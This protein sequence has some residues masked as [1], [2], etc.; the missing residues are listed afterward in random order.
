MELE[1]F[2]KCLALNGTNPGKMVP[3][4][5]GPRKIGSPRK[6]ELENFE[7]CLALNG[8]NPG[9]M[10]SGKMAP[11]KNGPGKMPPPPPPGKND[12]WK[13]GPR[14]TQKRKIMGWVSSIVVCAWNVGMWSIYENPKLDNK[15]KTRKQRQN[16]KQKIVGW[17]LIIVVYLCG[18]FGYDQSMKTQNSRTNIPGLL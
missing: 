6:M 11:G 12:P 16:R 8:T 3:G 9:K 15:H 7:K 4:K 5:N 17:A 1:N 14:E 2:E 18:M 10:I 13:N